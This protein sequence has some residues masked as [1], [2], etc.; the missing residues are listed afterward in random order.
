[1]VAVAARCIQ[2]IVASNAV[3]KIL[4]GPEDMTDLDVLTFLVNPRRGLDYAVC[5]MDRLRTNGGLFILVNP[6]ADLATSLHVSDT[7]SDHITSGKCPIT[8]G[9]FHFFKWKSEKAKKLISPCTTWMK[10]VL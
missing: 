4:S 3:I 2:A 8:F 5:D 7:L 10:K 1:M 9:L 6:L